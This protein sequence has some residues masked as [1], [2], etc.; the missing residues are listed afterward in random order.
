MS[1]AVERETVG[2]ADLECL[3]F[4]MFQIHLEDQSR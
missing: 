4:N 2:A 1:S 3:M